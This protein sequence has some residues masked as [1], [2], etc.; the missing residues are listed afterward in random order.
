MLGVAAM[1][2]Q[3]GWG[4]LIMTLFAVGFSLPLSAVMLGVG[5]SRLTVVATKAAAPLRYVAGVL[6]LVAGFWLLMTI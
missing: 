2:G 1:R 4:A 6:L 3:P 5:V